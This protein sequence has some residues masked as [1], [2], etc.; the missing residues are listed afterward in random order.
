MDGPAAR[1]GRDG[2][3]TKPELH[4]HRALDAAHVG[5][6]YIAEPIEQTLLANGCNLIGHCLATC[7]ADRNVC[8]GRIETITLARQEDA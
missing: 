8:F 1:P 5:G 7:P 2:G 3:S 6:R 4:T